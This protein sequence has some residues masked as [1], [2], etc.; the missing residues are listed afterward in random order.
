MNESEKTVYANY[1]NYAVQY[2]LADDTFDYIYASRGVVLK[3]VRIV[4]VCESSK[5]LFD[6]NDYQKKAYQ[7]YQ[8]MD[9]THLK[10]IYSD[11][12]DEQKELV[13]DFTI[14]KEGIQLRLD[15]R[16]D[17]DFHFN[18]QLY[19][20]DNMVEDTFAVCL[21]RSGRDLRSAF[22]PSASTIDHALF[23][24]KKDAVLTFLNIPKV[25]LRFNWDQNLYE[26]DIST[27]GNDYTRGFSIR[28]LENYYEKS[29][30]LPYKPIN[31]NNTFPTPPAGWMTWYAVQFDASEDT[32]MANAEWMAENLLDYGANVLWVDWEWYHGNFSGIG[33]PDVDSF[34]P[35]PIQY[36]KGLKEVADN[37]SK[38][39][40]TP[41]LWVGFTNDPTKNCFI[42]DNP[43]TV[44]L[45]KPTWCG[46]YFF[47]LSHPKYIK[48]FIPKSFQQVI[49]WGYKA[50]K[51]DC[52]PT[53]IEYHDQYHDSMYDSSKTTEEAM[54]EAVQ[55][56]R[57]V[58]GHDFYMLS[59]SGRTTRHIM[60]ACDI[61]DAARI[62]G[63]IF[64]WKEFI[65]QCIKR[66]MKFYQYHN[67][68]FYNDPDNVVLRSK[69]NS[70]D[71]ALSRLSFVSLMGLPITIG[72]QFSDLS[73][74]RIEMLRRGLPPIDAHPMDLRDNTTDDPIVRVNLSIAREFE[75]WNV[76][77]ILNTT[78]ASVDITLDLSR[79][80]HLSEDSYLVYDYWNKK[81]LG[82]FKK[83]VPLNLS[84]FASC[85]LCVRKKLDRPQ[86]LSTSRH[87]TQGAIDIDQMKWDQEK[88]VLSAVSNV[89][90]GDLY[91]IT[92]YVPEDLRP[93]NEGNNTTFA[94]FVHVNGPIWK[95]SV[96]PEQTG[97]LSWS[98]AFHG[99]HPK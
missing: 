87:I 26:F 88:R 62:G 53:T 19:W 92:F 10:I 22:G 21:N 23:D 18:G 66:V 42:K 17:L 96:K 39:G 40:L 8:S 71:Q 79:D 69:F 54:R 97:Q 76:V 64:E 68:L 45:Q 27:E 86:I 60:M 73:E 84:P 41:A 94:K 67:V 58:V 6:M 44:L 12:P 48:E 85:V 72:D 36:P 56:A 95:C 83:S 35:D 7:W 13:L 57:D 3:N 38:L 75:N 2:H 90:K 46:Q 74:D 28:V 99:K 20:G 37:L 70:Y 32:V 34:H 4:E 51:W 30:H 9:A 55:Q 98:V 31:K 78:E 91:T 49:D 15:C 50:L 5:K 52:L 33:K 16:G 47:D 24:R 82:N 63:D 43:E 65:A 93:F 29:L 1:R 25:D 80:L 14:D 59:C 89:V 81:Y 61:F 77:D 11:G